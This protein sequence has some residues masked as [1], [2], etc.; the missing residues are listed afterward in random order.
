MR[1][2]CNSMYDSIVL[3]LMSRT[4]HRVELVWQ[5]LKVVTLTLEW[6]EMH[7]VRVP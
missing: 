2:I 5:H 1:V 7:E 4:T 3:F 6:A